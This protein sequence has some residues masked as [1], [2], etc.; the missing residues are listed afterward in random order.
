LPAAM[1][2]IVGEADTFTFNFP[3]STFN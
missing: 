1:I 2:Q 3:L